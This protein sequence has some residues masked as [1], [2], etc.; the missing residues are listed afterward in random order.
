LPLSNRL[1]LPRRVA[2]WHREDRAAQMRTRR[3]TVSP[4]SARVSASARK[5]SQDAAVLWWRWRH[6]FLEAKRVELEA[7]HQEG[8]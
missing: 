6:N 5:L 3:Q 1:R 8:R 4:T 2:L 7:R